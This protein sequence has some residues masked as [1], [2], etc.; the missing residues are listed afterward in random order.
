MEELDRRYFIGDSDNVDAT[1]GFF[2]RGQSKYHHSHYGQKKNQVELKPL[3]S[4]YIQLVA[5][6]EEAQSDVQSSINCSDSKTDINPGA[7]AAP[8]DEELILELEE[9]ERNNRDDD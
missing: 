2:N 7:V 4:P 6:S 8:Y 1:D 3:Y 5:Q 9:F